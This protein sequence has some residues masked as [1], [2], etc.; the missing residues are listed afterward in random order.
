MAF[1]AP[2]RSCGLPRS[3]QHNKALLSEKK[4]IGRTLKKTLKPHLHKQCVIPP[5]SS[6]A[7]RA[8]RIPGSRESS[9]R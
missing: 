4:Q 1:T 8:L 5:D 9:K 6:A 7:S 2:P 3:I